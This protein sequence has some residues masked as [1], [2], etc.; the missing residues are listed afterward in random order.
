MS[1]KNNQRIYALAIAF[2]LYPVLCRF[3]SKLFDSELV[4]KLLLWPGIIIGFILLL[5]LAKKDKSTPIKRKSEID[6]IGTE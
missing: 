2:I 6:K 1:K 3:I 4:F 5:V